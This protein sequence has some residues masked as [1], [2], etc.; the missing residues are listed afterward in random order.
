MASFPTA[1][2]AREQAQSYS[3]I[4]VEVQAI[5]TA[6]IAAIAANAFAATVTDNTAMTNSTPVDTTSQKY[7]NVWKATDTDAVFVEQ[8]NE[9]M[10]HF[11]SKGYAISRVT[12]TAVSSDTFYW[13]LTW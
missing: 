10:S 2:Q 12:A 4:S 6:I 5:E 9:V 7:F 1:A 13:S 3:V 11:T 8:M